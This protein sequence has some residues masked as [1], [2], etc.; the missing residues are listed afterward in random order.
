MRNIP[1]VWK[2]LVTASLGA[3]LALAAFYTPTAAPY[4]AAQFT[5]VEAPGPL[6]LST[7]LIAVESGVTAAGVST[8][9]VIMEVLNG[10]AWTVAKTAVQ[11][12]TQ[13]IVNWINS[14]FEGSPGF[15]TDLEENLGSLADAVAEDFLD[16]L[17]QVI[18]NNT[19]ISVRSPFQDQIAGALRQE[20][21]RTTSS[22]GFDARNPYTLGR[23]SSDPE[24]F[25]RGDF[26]QGG[27]NAWF[28]LSQDRNNN[29]YGRYELAQNEL[30][31]RIDRQAQGRIEELRWGSGFLSWRGNCGPH[32]RPSGSA[33][34]SHEAVHLGTKDNTLGC[35]IRTPGSMVENALGIGVTSPFR[36][37]EL[38]DSV[39]EIVG[40]LASQLVTQVI[41]GS[42]LSG[43][44]RPASGGG[45]SFINRAG[46]GAE[47]QALG[48]SLY[49]G[50][51]Q[52]IAKDRQNAVSYR[53]SW[54]R[55]ADAAAA[56]RD[57]CRNDSTRF[58]EASN[59]YETARANV[60]RASAAIRNIDAMQARTESAKSV[61]T[62]SSTAAATV[63]REYNALMSSARI[64]SAGEATAAAAEASTTDPD[65][66]YS[67]MQRSERL[68]RII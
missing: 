51:A 6:L 39:N 47:Y 4:A 18:E 56:A 52:G 41:G 17:D 45:P 35:R 27:F 12:L 66:T 61:A 19:G 20:F 68:C 65:S 49:N 64:P 63:V 50:F 38:A 31:R 29:P 22:Y 8:Q 55:I 23:Y 60:E 9:S 42:G 58:R 43:V 21:Y 16:G 2:K 59:T 30:W 57:A 7:K 67:Q 3:L 40:A 34:V 13:S 26:R 28:K 48:S 46:S 44:S 1:A 24:A 10:I 14:G 53:D 25:T 62:A 37:L 33:Q 11:S 5:T 54:S 15:I 32:G 36:Q